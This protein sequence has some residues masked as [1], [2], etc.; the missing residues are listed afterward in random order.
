MKT[1]REYH[2]GFIALITAIVFSVILMVVAITLSTTG[3]FTRGQILDAEH[4]EH[5]RSLAEACVDVALLKLVANP[6]YA[7]G[8]TIPVSSS[9]CVISSVI[10]SGSNFIIAT[11]A[12]FPDSTNGAVT[13][14]SVVASKSTL[15]IS[16]WTE[17]P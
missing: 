17:L 8:E 14:L 2:S 15:A 6:L 5:S 3:Y 16:S 12:G 4:K 7:G 11:T 9:A 10:P 13:R 1:V